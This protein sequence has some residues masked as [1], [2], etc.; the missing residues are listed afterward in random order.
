M[1]STSGEN[2]RIGSSG[3]PGIGSAPS[4]DSSGTGP[5]G[6][7]VLVS[8]I[9]LCVGAMVVLLAIFMLVIIGF[10]ALSIMYLSVLPIIFTTV[11]VTGQWAWVPLW[12]RRMAV[13]GWA[14]I[15]K[16]LPQRVIVHMTLVEGSG[17]DAVVIEW[18]ARPVRSS[19]EFARY[20]GW[21]DQQLLAVK[22]IS[23]RVAPPD[24]P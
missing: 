15:P 12:R 24:M 10:W 21:Y 5:Q 19:W 3:R 22:G 1:P 7:A 20:Y 23:R 18:S 13:A 17:S 4:V 11:I 6:P 2:R 8:F 9:G 14:N 16:P